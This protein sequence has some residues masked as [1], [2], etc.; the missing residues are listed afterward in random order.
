MPCDNKSSDKCGERKPRTS[1]Q[2]DQGLHC[3]LTESLDI[4]ECINEEQMPG[5]YFA[6]ALMSRKCPDQTAQMHWL[7]HLYSHMA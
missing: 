3:P 2:Y 6:H 7:I 4:T 1:A 5:L